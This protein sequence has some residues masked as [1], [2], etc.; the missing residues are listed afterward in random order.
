MGFEVIEVPDLPPPGQ[1]SH[2]VKK[3]KM[4]FISGQTANREA[5]AGNLDAGAQADEVFGYLKSAIEAAG[6]DMS[7]IVKINIFLTDLSQFPSIL[8]WRPKYFDQ[9]YPAAT[10]VVVASMVKRELIMEIEAIAIL[11]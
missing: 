8:E 1:F 10:C 6:G 7:D 11:D 2:V 4:V 3:G 5:K 9:P